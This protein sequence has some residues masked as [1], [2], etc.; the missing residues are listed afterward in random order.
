MNIQ[1]LLSMDFLHAQTYY[2]Y[3]VV[4]HIPEYTPGFPI[5]SNNVD[6]FFIG[7]TL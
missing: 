1:E 5:H 2:R 7:R 6:S 4:A 3:D